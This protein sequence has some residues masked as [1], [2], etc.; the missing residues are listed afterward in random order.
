MEIAKGFFYFIVF[1]GFLFTAACGLLFSWIDRKVT[2]RLQ[3]RAGPPILQPLYDLVKLLGKEVLIPKSA[4]RGTFVFAPLIGL[5]GVT[6]S[7]SILWLANIFGLSFA[8]DIIVIA[9]LL[10][11]PS[12]SMMLGGLSSGNPLAVTGARREMKLVIGYELPFVLAL[13]TMIAKNGFSLTISS[14]TGSVGIASVSGA[15]AFVVVLLCVQAKL[16]LP[17]FDI[18]E[19]ETEIMEGPYI[20]YSGA[21]FGVYKLTQA[22]SFVAL[23]VFM[24]TL[25][26]GGL[27]FVGLDILWSILKILL[28]L[29]L[30]IVIKNTNPRVRIDQAMTFNWW[31]LAPLGVVSLVL[32][33]IGR[34]YGF[35]WL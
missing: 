5:A 11:L 31:F 6:L 21:L 25:F 1:P 4:N 2:A 22:M 7:A 20:E 30:V 14:F 27:R 23:P 19:A 9:Y 17:P 18:A 34:A 35:S 29:V 3:W 32:C 26:L 24:A 33:L 28:V 8:G 10:L 15:L 12:L 13:L 16:G